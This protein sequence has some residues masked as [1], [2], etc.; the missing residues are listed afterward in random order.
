MRP[1]KNILVRHMNPVL[2]RGFTLLE[3]IIVMS[4]ITMLAAAVIPVFNGTFSAIER[5]HAIRDFVSILRYAQE[6][7]IAEVCE[8]RV[9]L[10]TENNS[11]WLMK[12]ASVK[13]NEK[14]FEMLDERVGEK[15][16]FPETLTIKSA[17]AKKDKELR[18]PFIAYYPNG[19]CDEASV[20]F[21]TSDKRRS[22]SVHTNSNKAH[23]EVVEQK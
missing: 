8:F 23:I 21:E 4:L 18:L 20:K 7:A 14:T 11:Y 12:L 2:A 9:Y 10:D 6:R 22:V 1:M 17:K 19:A 15:M 16:F 13:K 5:D 3:L